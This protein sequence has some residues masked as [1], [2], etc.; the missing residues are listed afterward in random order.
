[1]SLHVPASKGVKSANKEGG[2]RGQ[3]RIPTP[4][5]PRFG[6]IHAIGQGS[7]EAAQSTETGMKSLDFDLTCHLN[8]VCHPVTLGRSV[9]SPG[10]AVVTEIVRRLLDSEVIRS[11]IVASLPWFRVLTSATCLYRIQQVLKNRRALEHSL[12]WTAHHGRI[13]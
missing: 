7:P 12:H 11:I 3:C 13:R 8:Q 1:M 9:S 4:P 2:K 6:G 10:D 5:V